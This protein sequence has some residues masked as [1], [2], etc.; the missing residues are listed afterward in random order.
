MEAGKYSTA[1]V[2]RLVEVSPNTLY[3]WI[4]AK[5]FYVPP[6]GSVGGVQVRLWSDEEVEAVKKY[7]ARFYNKGRG[8]GRKKSSTESD[9]RSGRI[10]KR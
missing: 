4:A 7:K 3:R 6:V 8:H 5:E 2:A 9:R 1:E 10:K